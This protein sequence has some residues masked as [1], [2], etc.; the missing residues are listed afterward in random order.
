MLETSMLR[1]AAAG[2]V[3]GIED[4][5]LRALT[6]LEQTLPAR[7]RPRV[8]ALRAATISAAGG[9]PTVDAGTLT[10]VAAAA[11]NS[12]R[13]RFEYTGHD[14]RTSVRDVEPHTPVY[15]GRRWYLLAWDSAAARHGSARGSPGPVE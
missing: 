3:T 5:S 14:G 10:T 13:L 15:T 6:K 7:L 12:E 4:R 1:A 2:T 9:G 11:H 8:D